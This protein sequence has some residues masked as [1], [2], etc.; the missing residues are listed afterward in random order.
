M[1]MDSLGTNPQLT[2]EFV[3][4]LNAQLQDCRDQLQ[5]L[6]EENVSLKHNLE[7]APQRSGTSGPTDDQAVSGLKAEIS[8]LKDELAALQITAEGHRK[9][10]ATW[11]ERYEKAKT[12]ITAENLGDLQRRAAVEKVMKVMKEDLVPQ[13]IT[14]LDTA[15]ST[16]EKFVEFRTFMSKL[17]GSAVADTHATESRVVFDKPKLQILPKA[18]IAAS[19]GGFAFFGGLLQWCDP[20][21]QNALLICPTRHYTP[22]SGPADAMSSHTSWSTATQWASLASQRREIFDTDGDQL[23]YAGTFLV[24]AGPKCA[25]PEYWEGYWRA[26]GFPCA[27]RPPHEGVQSLADMDYKYDEDENMD[28]APA[29]GASTLSEGEVGLNVRAM[30][31]EPLDEEESA[32][33]EA[34]L[35]CVEGGKDE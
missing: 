24:H 23:I 8:T 28:A 30:E 16:P 1:T 26:M 12:S 35:E 20:P 32:K 2:A 11:R 22:H 13:T 31:V 34:M 9:D 7:S 19:D 17:S 33:V 15:P 6:N 14:G 25:G 21:S 3:K 4:F 27:P 5:R 10:A 18:A 29:E